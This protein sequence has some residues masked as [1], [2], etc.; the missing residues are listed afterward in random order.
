M[1][2]P[3]KLTLLVPLTS[4]YRTALRMET[5]QISLLTLLHESQ[6]T[7]SSQGCQKSGFLAP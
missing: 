3:I 6:T 5:H 7:L 1:L 4:F 2:S